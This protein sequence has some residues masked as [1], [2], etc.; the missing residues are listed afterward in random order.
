MAAWNGQ[1]YAYN[2][3]NIARTAPERSGVYLIWNQ[4]GWIYVGESNNIQRRLL[5][6]FNG[7][8]A[9]ITRHAPTG[10]GF[11]LVDA[12]LR[13]QRQN[14]LILALSPPCNRMLG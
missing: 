6:H 3:D 10:F 8:N 5:E 9:C 2:R 1:G 13:V 7:D 12:L 14:E 11:E 4:A